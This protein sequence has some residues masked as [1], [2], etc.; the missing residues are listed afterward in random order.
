MWNNSEI[1]P[2]TVLSAINSG[3]EKSNIRMLQELFNINGNNKIVVSG[4]NFGGV[5]RFYN[6][7]WFLR[8][9]RS[10]IMVNFR[11]EMKMIFLIFG[12]KF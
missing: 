3:G 11:K 10:L 7:K 6:A 4:F 1:D 9:N 2:F 8:T 12:K 5:P